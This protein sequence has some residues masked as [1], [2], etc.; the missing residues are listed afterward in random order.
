M[1]LFNNSTPNLTP[2]TFSLQ[3][4]PAYNSEFF[5]EDRL[6]IIFIETGY[7]KAKINTT[8]FEFNAPGIICI[9]ETERLTL[10]KSESFQGKL[11]TFSPDVIRNYFTFQ[12][13]RNYDHR[14]TPEDIH[15]VIYLSIF[16]Q[17]FPQYIGYVTAYESIMK[18]INTTLDKLQK[19]HQ[20]PSCISQLLVEILEPI[21]KLVQTSLSV[22]NLIISD[23][24]FEIKDVL[25]YLHTHCKE[26]IT[27]PLLSK[28]F[29]VNRTTLS[30]RFF[31][32]TGETIITYLNKY[33]VNLAA[34]LLRESNQSI[35]HIAQEVG[36]NDTAYFAK[37]FKKYMFYTP[38]GYRNHYVSLCQ[39]HKVD[40]TQEEHTH[41]L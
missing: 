22:S 40:D 34:I 3:C 7:G 21:K 10:M 1:K 37:L 17:R 16:F 8:S 29:H 25:L 26:K 24:S 35:S 13:T 4:I 12:N 20:S 19:R 28:K 38:S 32:A 18:Q 30:D 36:F 11:L 33:R 5:F 23:P 27:I 14:F 9:N 6:S 31:Q 2:S 15:L 41:P 39:I